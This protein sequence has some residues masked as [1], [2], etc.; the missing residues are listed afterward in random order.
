MPRHIRN[1]IIALVL[2]VVALAAGLKGYVHHQFKKNIDNTLSSMQVFAR[3]TYSDLS[4]S[5]LSGEVKLD[6]IRISSD[7][8]PEE[9]EIGS[10]V[11]QTPGFAYM[12]KGPSSFREGHFPERLGLT[13][14]DFYLDM[15]GDIGDWMN[16]MVARMQRVMGEGRKICG[17]KAIFSPKD[18]AE[19][20]YTRIA[21]SLNLSY[22]FFGSAQELV[23]KMSGE[24]RTMANFDMT[25]TIAGITGMT[26]AEMMQQMPKLK[27]VEMTFTDDSYTKRL[28]NFCSELDGT[29]KEEFIEAE[30]AESDQYFFKT[31]GFAPGP[32]LREA[33]KDFLYA[34]GEITM[35]INPGENFNPMMIPGMSKAEIV[36][37]LNIR[38]KI[39]GQ[40]VTDLSFRA[41]DPAYMQRYERRLAKSLTM[42]SATADLP[43]D[44][45][46]PVQNQVK[47]KQPPKY[48]VIS[49]PSAPRHLR[50]YVRITKKSGNTT[51]GQLIRVDAANLY[52][53]KKVSGGKFTMTI[54]KT[55]IKKLES[56]YSK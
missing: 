55:T 44:K 22:E 10:V 25:A 34:P 2:A 54:P 53:Q 40:L 18:Y 20:G 1:I 21:S 45:D 36:D 33:Y 7:A 9:L 47:K 32:G 13:I 5:L 11:F 17:G 15:N 52:V 23:I 8:L 49:I 30:A 41:P 12:L 26:Q 43:V 6:N 38:L 27:S 29:K 28:I 14:N 37:S 48:H 16:K 56:Y 4:T 24:T 46:E 31:W 50:N 19:M 42:E 51:K 3:V 39:N 35:N